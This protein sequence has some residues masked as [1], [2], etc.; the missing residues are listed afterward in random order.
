MQ[1]LGVLIRLGEIAHY[2]YCIG[3]AWTVDESQVANAARPLQL[4]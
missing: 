1:M 3:D 4:R 2:R